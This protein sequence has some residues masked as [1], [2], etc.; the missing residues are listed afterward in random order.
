MWRPHSLGRSNSGKGARFYA[1]DLVSIRSVGA[2]G[3][4]RS[5]SDN[6]NSDPECRNGDTDGHNQYHY[7]AR[8][9]DRNSAWY[10]RNHAFLD[11]NPDDAGNS[12]R[13][14]QRSR[15]PGKR[16]RRNTGNPESG[17]DNWPLWH[18]KYRCSM[19]TGQQRHERW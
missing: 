5:R 16:D 1:K 12:N 11:G 14:P 3:W 7:I 2:C 18:H 10:H 15:K 8:R 17:H 4:S 9:D 6:R 13:L 19:H